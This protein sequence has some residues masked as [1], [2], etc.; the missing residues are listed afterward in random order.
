MAYRD[1]TVSS[2]NSY[3]RPKS[4]PILPTL[5]ILSPVMKLLMLKLIVIVG[6]WVQQCAASI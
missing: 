1:D 3:V 4:R 6:Q 2:S 5:L